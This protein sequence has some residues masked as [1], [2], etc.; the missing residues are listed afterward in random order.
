M[1]RRGPGRGIAQRARRRAKSPDPLAPPRSGNKTVPELIVGRVLLARLMGRH[2]DRVTKYLGEGMPVLK[3]GG[4]GKESEFDAISCLAWE[5]DR[6]P[7]ATKD[8]QQCRYY[9]AQADKI[10][11]EIR[12]R[13]GEL[14]EAADVEHR[15]AGMVLAMRERI[16]S[17]PTTAL[18]RRLLLHPEAEA[19]LVDLVDEALAELS[20]RRPP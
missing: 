19:G 7:M 11:Q 6:R 2:P 14:I 3:A 5:R 12:K 17:L 20:T 10:E 9:K 1:T 18:Q 15:W 16:L 4:R 13:A 8:V